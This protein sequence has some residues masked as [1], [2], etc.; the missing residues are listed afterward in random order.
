MSEE[1]LFSR[2]AT[3]TFESTYALQHLKNLRECSRLI[4]HP[5][6]PL[7]HYETCVIKDEDSVSWKLWLGSFALYVGLHQTL[8]KTASFRNRLFVPQ[9]FAV[10]PAFALI[11]GGGALYRQRTLEKLA[12]PPPAV[13]SESVLMHLIRESYPFPS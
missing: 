12:N 13:Q 5:P 2:S 10:V 1:S 3:L 9:F 7:S 11:I 8:I 6:A 4:S